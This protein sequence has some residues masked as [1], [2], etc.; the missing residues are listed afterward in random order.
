MFLDI[1]VVGHAVLDHR[2]SD[3]VLQFILVTL[4]EC[5]ELVVDVYDK[6]LPDIGE[7]V[8][9]LRIYLAS[10]AIAMQCRWT[11]QIQECSF[12]LA[13][14][15]RQHKAGVVTALTVV[16]CVGDH[17]HKPFGKIRQ[18]LV[19]LR[20]TTQLAKWGMAFS[21]KGELLLTST[22]GNPLKYSCMGLTRGEK[23]LSI[24]E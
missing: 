1:L 20:T 7:R 13:L 17:R 19:R 12:E 11:E 4:V 2:A 10:V 22:N 3:E 6:I 24:I 16:H 21:E 23:L 9:L 18:P 14:L 8:L 15:A 5:F